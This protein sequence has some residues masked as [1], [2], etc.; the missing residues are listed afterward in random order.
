MSLFI[1][2]HLS[3]FPMFVI[4]FFFSLSP[5]D[6]VELLVKSHS[7]KITFKKKS[8]YPTNLLKMND[9]TMRTELSSIQTQMNQSTNEVSGLFSTIFSLIVCE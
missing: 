7:Y 2:P 1:V 3:S 8:K 5:S 6:S 9:D 4:S